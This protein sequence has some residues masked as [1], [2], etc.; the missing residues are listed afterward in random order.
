MSLHE[1][2]IDINW[3]GTSWLSTDILTPVGFAFH[4]SILT[5]IFLR[6]KYYY[7]LYMLMFISLLYQQEEWINADRLEKEM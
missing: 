5:W 3:T 7:L 2:I 1:Q 6:S 4:N